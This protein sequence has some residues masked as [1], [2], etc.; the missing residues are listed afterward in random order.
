MD[1][2][3]R[4]SHNDIVVQAMG[5]RVDSRQVIRW[6]MEEPESRVITVS[7]VT[8]VAD[9]TEIWVDVAS[10][11]DG[12]NYEPG[13]CPVDIIL[14]ERFNDWTE[15]RK[16]LDSSPTIICLQTPTQKVSEAMKSNMD[17]CRMDLVQLLEE[18]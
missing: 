15:A 11:L 12:V 3:S 1:C 6:A 10:G 7:S 13:D 17:K 2:T 14:I 4:F 16:D 5:A 8:Q 18:L 9:L